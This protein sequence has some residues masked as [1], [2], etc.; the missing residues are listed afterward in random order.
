MWPFGNRFRSVNSDV[1]R[2]LVSDHQMDVD[3]IS[4]EVRCVERK[5]VLDGGVPVTFLRLFRLP[6]VK[7]KGVSVSGWET[8]DE[9]PDLIAFEGH[10]TPEN[11]PIL[12][13]R[14]RS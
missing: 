11:V 8:F 5:G 13:P 7:K 3:T 12:K 1:W 14:A 10:L 9:H 4:R 2:H 6:E